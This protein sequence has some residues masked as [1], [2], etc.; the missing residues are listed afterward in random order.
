MPRP[1]WKGHISF[2]MVNIPVTLFPAD[3]P[4]PLSFELLDDRDLAPVGYRKV[5]KK[6]GGEV[7]PDHIVRGFR[8]DDGQVVVVSDEDLKQASPEKTQTLEIRGFVERVQV[9]PL[10]FERPYYL[11]PT[12]AGMKGYTLLREAMAAS[13]KAAVGTVVLRARQHLSLLFV[14]GPWLVMNTLRYP[15]ELKNPRDLDVPKKSPTELG[16]SDKELKMA[17]R[18]VDEMVEPWAPEQYHDEYRDELL[19]AIRRKAESGEAKPTAEV[20]E[21]GEAGKAKV[22][23]LMTLLKQSVERASGDKPRRRNRTA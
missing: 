17:Q 12:A 15:N 20:P 1:L 16:I 13:D 21:P 8:L 14:D 3:R 23:D 10:Y 19:A 5:N 9:P 22:S 7:P 11:Q 6:N 4:D 18:L 2:G